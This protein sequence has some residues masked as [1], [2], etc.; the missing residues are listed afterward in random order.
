MPVDVAE[1][2]V[3]AAERKRCSVSEYATTV[4]AEALTSGEHT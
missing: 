2:L 4:L 3:A 1:R